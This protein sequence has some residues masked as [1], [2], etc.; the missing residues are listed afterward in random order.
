MC[1]YTDQNSSYAMST[2]PVSAPALGLNT[3]KQYEFKRE[4]TCAP[5]NTNSTFIVRALRYPN[6][7]RPGYAYLYG[8]SNPKQRTE[9]LTWQSFTTDSW[10][11]EGMAPS[12]EVQSVNPKGNS[13]RHRTLVA[14]AKPHLG[15]SRLLDL[16][17]DT[18]QYR[19]CKWA[20]TRY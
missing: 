18:S 11:T 9:N 16:G 17:E 8:K 7:T 12:Y 13:V 1:F 4:T 20:K 6:D 15:P 19:S 3:Q 14:D 5:L 2:G 10:Q